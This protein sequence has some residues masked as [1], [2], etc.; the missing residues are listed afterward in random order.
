MFLNSVD[1]SNVIDGLSNEFVD[2]ELVVYVT[3][4]RIKFGCESFGRHDI[5]KLSATMFSGLKYSV[6]VADV[7]AI[8]YLLS[9]IV[10]ACNVVNPPS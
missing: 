10:T 7:E 8:L 2:V 9:D 3:D 4:I 5:L 6:V 1:V